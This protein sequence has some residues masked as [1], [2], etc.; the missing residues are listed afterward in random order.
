ML[1]G[2]FAVTSVAGTTGRLISLGERLCGDGFTQY[3]HAL[4]YTGDGHIVEAEPGGAR[5]RAITD[6]NCGYQLCEWSTGLVPLTTAQRTAVCAA[7]RSYIGTPYSWPDYAALAAHHLHLPAPG[8]RAYI[9]STGHMICSQLVDQCYQDAGVHL[10]ADGRWPGY[11]MPSDLAG[12][13]A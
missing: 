2:D 11:V 12:L 7:A 1:P 4:I 5:C 3:D 6:A 9:A 13:L 8:L 10:F